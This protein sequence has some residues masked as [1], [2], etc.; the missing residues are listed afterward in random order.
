MQNKDKIEKGK[1]SILLKVYEQN[2]NNNYRCPN[3][4]FKYL[5]NNSR[6]KLKI[7]LVIV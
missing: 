3:Y 1:D 5:T 4:L 2:Y 7:R 6:K